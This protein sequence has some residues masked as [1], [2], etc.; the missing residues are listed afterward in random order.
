MTANSGNRGIIIWPIAQKLFQSVMYQQRPRWTG[1]RPIPVGSMCHSGTRPVLPWD[2]SDRP[3]SINYGRVDAPPSAFRTL[4][5]NFALC[6]LGIN[7]IDPSNIR[8]QSYSNRVVIT[9]P[10]VVHSLKPMPATFFSLSGVTR[11]NTG[12]PLGGCVVELYPTATDHG[13]EKTIS[14]A[15]GLYYFKSGV[16][17]LNY[18]VVAYKAGGTDVFGTTKNTL[19]VT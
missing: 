18:Y 5:L 9:Q 13:Q 2:D 7:P 16:R 17:G 11:D 4:P 19:V 15:D 1:G 3:P 6:E 8:I 10:S 14:N 12:V